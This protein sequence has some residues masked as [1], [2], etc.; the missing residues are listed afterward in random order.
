MLGRHLA[1]GFIPH[2]AAKPEHEPDEAIEF[3]NSTPKVVISNTLTTSP[4]EGTTVAGGDVASIVG[5]LKAREGGD[6]IAYGGAQLVQSLVAHEL[7]DDLHLF[8]NPTGI[9]RGLPV[10]P[11]GT[12]RF[13]TVAATRFECGITALHLRPRR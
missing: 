4:W 1:E 12:H 9:G 13:Q 7:L 11:E 3:M 5:D 6:L 10:F 2:W 8:I